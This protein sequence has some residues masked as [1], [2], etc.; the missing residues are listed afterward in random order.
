MTATIDLETENSQLR[1][2][3]LLTQV[4]I[5]QRHIKKYFVQAFQ[6]L[7]KEEYQ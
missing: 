1:I 2:V 4:P 3:L 7:H 6:V 5:S